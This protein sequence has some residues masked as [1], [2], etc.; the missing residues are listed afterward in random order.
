MNIR[1]LLLPS[2]SSA[3]DFEALCLA[4]YQRDWG[5]PN[6]QLN[7]VS[8]QS[9]SGVDIFG[10]SAA[11]GELYGVQC[12]V[13]AG[14]AANLRFAEIEA[15][16]EK[17]EKFEPR[18]SNFIVATSARRDA[19]LQA[20]VRKLS[21]ERLEK[22]KFAVHVAAWED[23]II[24]LDRYRDIACHFFPF[25][26]AQASFSDEA[27]TKGQMPTKSISGDYSE[28]LSGR[29]RY[30]MSLL[31][32]GR[33]YDAITV[34][35]IAEMLGAE[36]I[37]DVSNF[38]NGTSEP[39][40][41]F[42][43]SFASRFGVNAEWLIHAEDEAFYCAEPIAFS[44]IDALPLLE[45]V[46]PENIFLVRSKSEYGECIIVVKVDEWRYLTING[47]WHVSS[48]VGATGRS[49]LVDLYD[50]ILRILKSKLPCHGSI[51]EAYVFDQIK[52]GEIY[53]GSVLERHNGNADWWVAL[54]DV[55]RKQTK[56]N[57]Y[58]QWYGQGF[59]DAQDIL[60]ESLS[61]AMRKNPWNRDDG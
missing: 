29:L 38:F 51:L 30:V 18:L 56:A 34:S 41:S 25:L 45:S 60:R 32:E 27:T 54:L 57:L 50:L 16:V 44:P 1:E 42:L 31:N 20:K 40:I 3:R 15:E 8:G 14:D 26:S 46:S 49:Q 52:S 17:A 37:S 7:G 5:D 61:P 10:R 33:R 23:L 19:R 53:P 9:Q 22:G 36:R 11:D 47:L 13:R 55:D 21:S 4:L 59:L 28:A 43:R 48:H 58:K 2:L 24:L 12:K 39:P 35:R 6:A